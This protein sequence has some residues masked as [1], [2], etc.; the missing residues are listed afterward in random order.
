MAY[1]QALAERVRAAAGEREGLIE[2]RMFGGLGFILNGNMAVGIAG[3]QLIVRV[4]ADDEQAAQSEPHTRPFAPTGRPMKG[5]VTV[6]PGGTRDDAEL[7][8][9]VEWGLA[10]AAG[11][12][13]K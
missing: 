12:P 7:R 9:W 13:P 11:L 10:Y 8:S 2:K 6:A 5:W 3:D 1:D 4:G